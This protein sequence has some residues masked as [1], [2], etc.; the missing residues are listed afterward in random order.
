LA[1]HWH[2]HARFY[3]ALALG[4]AAAAAARAL[5]WPAPAA[6]GADAFF[7]V[8]V[9]WSL[10]LAATLTGADLEKKADIEDEGAFVILLL[11]LAAIVYTSFAIFTTLN[12]GHR[13]AAATLIVLAGAPLSWLMLQSVMA[14][15]YADLYYRRNERKDWI[16]PVNFPKTPEPGPA[17][18]VYLAMVVGMT[19]Q[20]ADTNVQST[21]MRRAVT[22]HS[23]VS[24]F[25]NT[26]L[27]AMAVN[28]AVSK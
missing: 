20:V 15:R 27:I 28:A 4:L 13:D 10:W 25:F 24:F 21:G 11:T 19:A 2:H 18:F 6:L 26:V 9:L 23:V 12:G 7:L 5:Q 3:V 17:E 16:A 8:F 14:F 22:L 1:H